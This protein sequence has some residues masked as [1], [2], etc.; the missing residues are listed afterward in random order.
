[1]DFRHRRKV[2]LIAITAGLIVMLV[3]IGY[4][5]CFN[6]EFKPVVGVLVKI[7][8]GCC[9]ASAGYAGYLTKKIHEEENSTK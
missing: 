3:L 6:L 4:A 5:S 9:F 8:I 7:Y 1:M 2:L